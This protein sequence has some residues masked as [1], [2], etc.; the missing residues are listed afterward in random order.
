MSD[1]PTLTSA[2][3]PLLHRHGVWLLLLIVAALATWLIV[4]PSPAASAAAK[5]GA[6]KNRPAPVQVAQAHSGDVGVYLTGLGTVMAN[7]NVTVHSRVDGQLLKLHFQ[8]GQTVQA[9]DLLAEIDPRPF[10]AQLAQAEG[11]KAKDEALLGNAKLDLQRYQTLLA[12]DSTSKQQVDTQRSLV[13]QYQAAIKADQ[14]TVAAARLN[15]TYS[16]VTAPASGRTGLRQ[17]D[18]GNI[19][20]A[21]DT[22]GLVVITQVQPINVL[23]TLPEV[24]LAQV[25]KPLNAGVKLPVDAYDREQKARLAAGQLLTVD[26]QIDL[27]TGTVKLKAQFANADR[28][29]FPNQFVN[30]RLLVDTVKNAVLIPSSAVQRGT[31]GTYVYVVNA[32]KTVS[33]RPIKLGPANGD[34]IAVASGLQAGETVVTDGA[35]KLKDGGKVS[36][37]DRAPAGDASAPAGKHKGGKHKPAKA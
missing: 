30:V 16:R 25:L 3:K 19:V 36:I 27:A 5:R 9:G 22:N 13:R 26:N 4:R 6:D 32:D 1:S 8:E 2:P 23:F 18:P 33:L 12:E 21:S 28:S 11:Q 10:Q 35:D 29:L 37:P 7:N 15:L 20:H 24:Q 31:P 14:G 34:E 17:V